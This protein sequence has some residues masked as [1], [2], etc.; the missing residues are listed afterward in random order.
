MRVF[1]PSKAKEPYRD[2][3]R[4]LSTRARVDVVFTRKMP[5]LSNSIVLDER[6]EQ[7]TLEMIKKFLAA[8][9][10][11]VVGGPDG[12]DYPGR[13]VSLGRYTLNHQ[14]AIIV[15]LDLIFRVK[16]PKHPYNKH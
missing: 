15:L 10:N 12:I 1:C 11:F 6:G 13:Q 16:F 3:I 4:E 8:D 5:K 7:V 2:A 14:I 9:V